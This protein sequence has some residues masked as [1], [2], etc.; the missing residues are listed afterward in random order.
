VKLQTLI[1][2]L[3][4]QKRD[5]IIGLSDK[6]WAC[7][8]IYFEELQSSEYLCMALEDEGFQVEREIAGLQTGF[9]GSYGNGKPIVAILGEFDAL[10]GL[11]QKKGLA[12]HA[13]VIAG[14]HG[15]GCGHNL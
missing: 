4:E 8:E 3:I 13:P 10:T 9:I 5:K 6:I 12:E 2:D 15:H 11:S 14:G 1:S 7:P